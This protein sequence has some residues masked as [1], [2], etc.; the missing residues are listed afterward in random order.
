MVYLALLHDELGE[1]ALR[2]EAKYTEL[3]YLQGRELHRRG[4]LG[5][6]FNQSCRHSVHSAVLRFVERLL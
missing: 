5:D 4:L 3:L 2:R 1:P 6:H